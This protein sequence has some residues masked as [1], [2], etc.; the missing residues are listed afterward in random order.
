MGVCIHKI[1][2]KR[3]KSYIKSPNWIFTK[4]AAINPK[5]KD[6]KCFQY[7]VTFALNHQK[8]DNHPERISNI[9]PFI[10]QYNW[11]DIDFPAGVKDW[12]KFAK[13]NK[14][15]AL[16]TLYTPHNKEEIKLAY[17]S[18]YNR[19]R[20]NQDNNQNDKIDKW[21]YIALGSVPTGDGFNRPI[22]SL[23]RLFRGI[24]SNNN[25]D[26]YCLG[27]LH[28]YRTDNAL[29]KHERLCNNHDYCHVEMPTNDNNILKYNHREK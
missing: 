7:S 18:K 24:T 14:E 11:K 25:E 27:C 6:N 1:D 22:Q 15:V 19:K 28:S 9:K 2:L 20:K 10:D 3:R 4:R 29:K 21:H 12:E 13:N 17:K 26:I 5:N 23:S 8:I 16:N